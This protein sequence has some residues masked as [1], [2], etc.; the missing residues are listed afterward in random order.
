MAIYMEKRLHRLLKRSHPAEML[1][2]RVLSAR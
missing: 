1:T 2:A